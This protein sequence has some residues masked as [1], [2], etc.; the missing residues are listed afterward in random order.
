MASRRLDIP[1]GVKVPLEQFLARELP[2]VTPA[3]VSQL[4]A[5]GRVR[6]NGKVARAGRRTW[7]GET[8]E[9]ELPA[10]PPPRAVVGPPIPTLTEAPGVLIV[11]KPAGVTTTPEPGQVSL[12]EL[13]AAQRGGFDVGGAALPG[14][15]HRLDKDTSGCL[16]LATTDDGVRALEAA[17]D[18]RRV[19]KRYLAFVRGQPADTGALDTPYTKG[20][21]G[22]YT[23]R[24]D[25][26]RRARLSWRVVERFA[27]TALLEIDLD[28]GRTHQ[29]RVQL[30]ETG[31]AVLGD[32]RYGPP[33]QPEAPRL[34]LHARSLRLDLD[35]GTLV[36]EAPLPGDLTALA[37]RLRTAAGKP[38][39]ADGSAP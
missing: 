30:S 2:N 14:V 23:T 19:E 28:T 13:V 12:I 27:D 20:P 11:D 9:L 1:R 5:E 31:H 39:R 8:V 37:E 25:S 17:F 33:G 21:D 35:G 38:E 32:T 4:L 22:R 16:A 6:V 10:P 15:V 24:L 34:A 18:A 7:G 26:P 3:R 36:A 29:I